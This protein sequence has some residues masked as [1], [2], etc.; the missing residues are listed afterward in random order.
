MT[1]MSHHLIGNMTADALY[2]LRGDAELQ[3]L[4]DALMAEAVRREPWQV[5]SLPESLKRCSEP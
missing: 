5:C 4:R 1:I 2:D 3:Q